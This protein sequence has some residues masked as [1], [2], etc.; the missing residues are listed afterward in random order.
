MTA[1]RL[2]AYVDERL[3]VG[4]GAPR[5]RESRRVDE[6]VADR[7]E[8][9]VPEFSSELEEQ[10]AGARQRDSSDEIEAT[11]IVRVAHDAAD[12]RG[13]PPIAGRDMHD[14]LGGTR[15]R[16][17]EHVS[18]SGVAESI[19]IAKQREHR[20]CPR[21]RRIGRAHAAERM[22]EVRPRE[23]APSDSR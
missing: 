20:E 11:A 10:L 5:L 14:R 13:N 22:H 23:P 9:I 16:D 1:S 12:P 8:G 2:T 4:E 7:D 15:E 19:S 18:C 3:E 21:E 17:A 6:M